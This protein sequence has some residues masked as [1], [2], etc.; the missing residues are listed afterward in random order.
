MIE[1]F[2]RS[3]TI[4]DT[5]TIVA[6][7]LAMA[8][9]TEDLELEEAVCT[10]GVQAV[11]ARTDLGQYY[12]AE[13]AGRV[14][15]SLMITYEWSDWRNGMVWWIQ[16]VYVSPE[17]RQQG[18][19]AGLYAHVKAIVQADDSLRGIRLYVDERNKRAQAVYTRLGMNGEHY[20]VFE[21]MK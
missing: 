8:R 18:I 14:V 19:Y 16:S 12:V 20:R 4:D 1:T 5:A 7:Q 13:Q 9:E 6:F 21:W 10:R 3:A 15:A 17:A 2:Y 11:F